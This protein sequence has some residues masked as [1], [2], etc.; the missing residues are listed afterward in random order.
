MN[1]GYR[2]TGSVKRR[3]SQRV[4]RLPVA[5]SEIG[6]ILPEEVGQKVCLAN[7]TVRMT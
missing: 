5:H 2:R 4:I 1:S 3:N 6:I 7:L